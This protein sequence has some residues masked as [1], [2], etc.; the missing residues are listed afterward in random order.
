VVV[1]VVVVVGSDESLELS[2]VTVVRVV[3]RWVE[4]EVIEI[5][6]KIAKVSTAALNDLFIVVLSGKFVPGIIPEGGIGSPPR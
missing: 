6:P 5:A 3:S 1:V 4:Q 2:W